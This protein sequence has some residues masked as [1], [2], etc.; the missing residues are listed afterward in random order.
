[1]EGTANRQNIDMLIHTIRKLNPKAKIYSNQQQRQYSG[2]KL[3]D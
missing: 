2:I 3:M 1:M